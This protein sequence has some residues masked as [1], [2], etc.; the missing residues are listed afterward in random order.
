MKQVSIT[1][2][3]GLQIYA[4]PD[5]TEGFSIADWTNHREPLIE[6]TGANVGIY[7]G[8]LDE[9]KATLWRVFVGASQPTWNQDIGYVKLPGQSGQFA[10]TFDLEDSQDVAIARAQI[11]IKQSGQ[12]VATDVSSSLGVKAFNLDAGTYTYSVTAS[13]FE[14]IV[15]QSFTV[16]ANATISVTMTRL[17]AVPVDPGKSIL[18]ILCLDQNGDAE[19]NV[20][21]D[22]RIVEVPS[23]DLNVAYK[24]TKQT[25]TSDSNGYATLQAIQ[26]AVYEYKRG[27]SDVWS[28]VT[29]GQGASTNVQSIIGAP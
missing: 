12:I 11:T 27:K 19:P 25:A 7:I 20:V 4:F 9:T 24:G 14:S 17:S 8:E 28:K 2:S 21:I 23:G 13:G 22:I 18:T 1:R 3:P 5:R 29:I 16:S 26:G 6:G 15:D 10:I